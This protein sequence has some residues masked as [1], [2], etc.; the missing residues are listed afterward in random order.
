MNAKQADATFVSK[1]I[2]F[3]KSNGRNTARKTKTNAEIPKVTDQ[4]KR[5]EYSIGLG[6]FSNLNMP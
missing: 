2:L 6:L 1:L 5:L 4:I 3:E